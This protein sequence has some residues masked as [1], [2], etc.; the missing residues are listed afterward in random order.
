[1]SKVATT[2]LVLA[3]LLAATSA[4][5]LDLPRKN[6]PL[7]GGTHLLRPE[8]ATAILGCDNGNTENAYFQDTNHRLGNLFNFGGGAVL[9]TVTFAHYGFGFAGPYNYDIELW[10]P[11][12]CTFIAARNGLVAANAAAAIRTETV[13]L[14][15]QNFFV[16]GN[17]IVTIDP[18]TCAAPNDCYPDMLYDDQLNVFCP[19]IVD[20]TVPAAADC[21]DQSSV[22]GPFLLRVETNNCPTPTKQGSWGDV[23]V[24]YR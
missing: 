11:V 16:T 19:I 2:T 6:Q 18:N 5:A 12:S 7:P 23:K 21:Y 14:C 10:D 13:N 20:A 1:M 22:T 8:S 9:S 3:G 24:L 4:L 15:P 17:V